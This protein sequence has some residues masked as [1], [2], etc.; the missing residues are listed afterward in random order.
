[1]SPGSFP[2]SLR[3]PRNSA[4][5]A[6]TCTARV[7]TTV[8]RR[9]DDGQDMR[10]VLHAVLAVICGPESRVALIHQLARESIVVTNVLRDDVA[11]V[12]FGTDDQRAAAEE[13]G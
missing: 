4:E 10:E 7:A 11:D 8:P 12:A 5:L 3:L 13:L 6:S 9:H 2:Q 1:M